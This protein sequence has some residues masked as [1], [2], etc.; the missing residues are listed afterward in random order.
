MLRYIIN[1]KLSPDTTLGAMY[2]LD[3]V[4]ENVVAYYNPKMSREEKKL[5]KNLRKLAK[6]SSSAWMPDYYKFLEKLAPD[7]P[8]GNE[9]QNT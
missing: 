8:D 3:H 2:N 1:S 9:I 6:V 4:Y 7:T 5:L